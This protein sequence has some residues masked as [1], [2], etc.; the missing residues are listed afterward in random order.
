MCYIWVAHYQGAGAMAGK[1]GSRVAVTGSFGFTG[2]A[3]TD[4][5]LA[6]GHAVVTRTRRSGI[7]DPLVNRITVR[8]ISGASVDDLAEALAGVDVLFNTL[9]LRFP[10]AGATFEGAVARSAELL[11]AARQAGV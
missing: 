3:L 2:R 11:A 6:A 7:G 8:P 1:S 10:R 4:R 9:W 5:L